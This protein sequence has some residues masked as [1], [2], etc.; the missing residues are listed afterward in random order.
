MPTRGIEPPDITVLRAGGGDT[1]GALSTL[2]VTRPAAFWQD[3]LGGAG[4]GCVQADGPVPS[5]FWLEDPQPQAMEATSRTEHPA[6]GTYQRHGPLVRFDRAAADLKPP[7]L[8]GQH[9][10]AILSGLGYDAADI[11]RLEAESVVWQELVGAD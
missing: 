2:F 3:L 5:R 7:P 11:E 8:A 6:W 1:A 10:N 4:I 9:N